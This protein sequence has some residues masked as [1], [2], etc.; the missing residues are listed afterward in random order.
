[1]F[2]YVKAYKPE[3]RIKEYEM[4]KAVYCSICKQI[5]KKYGFVTRFSLSYD[6]TFLMMLYLSLREDCINVKGGKCVYNPT[7]K[8][9]YIK[10]R[11]P[12]MPLAAAQIML[13]YKLLDNIEDEGFL[14]AFVA[15]AIKIFVNKGYK[16]AKLEFPSVEK[17]F[18]EYYKAQCQLEKNNIQNL[19][20]AAD[21]TAKMLSSLFALCGE[22]ENTVDLE[23]LGYCLGRWIYIL[24][25]AADI[26][27]DVKHNKY[28]PLTNE[29]RSADNINTFLSERLLGTL[30]FCTT[31]A[32]ESFE[33]IP[34]K[35]FKNILGNIIYLGLEQSMNQV[36]KKENK[37]K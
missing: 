34:I 14:K 29:V 17:I 23:R 19:D 18:A 21:P 9:S 37:S 1:M 31:E 27:E 4:Y 35:R 24:D 13:Y 11:L 16:K 25:A 32:A 3:L 33:L 20:Q 6:F 10:E 7:K 26:K 28:N 8:C 5:G 30:T 15:K 2:G 12:D 36:F 22:E